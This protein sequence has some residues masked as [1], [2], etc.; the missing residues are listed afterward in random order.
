MLTIISKC[1][2]AVGF[3]ENTYYNVSNLTISLA[4]WFGWNETVFVPKTE[5]SLLI[6][7]LY[8][9]IQFPG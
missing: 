1:Q 9:T 5:A 4:P 3:L 6:V 2:F 7:G 8:Y